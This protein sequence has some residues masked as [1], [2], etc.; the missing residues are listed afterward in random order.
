ME[1]VGEVIDVTEEEKEDALI[2]QLLEKKVT[3]ITEAMDR[4]ITPYVAVI[5][6]L[7]SCSESWAPVIQPIMDRLKK[8]LRN[9]H[10]ENIRYIPSK[11]DLMTP[12]FFTN[13]HKIRV[14]VLGQDPYHQPENPMGLAFSV[15]K[16]V[17]IP[18]SLKNIFTAAIECKAMS[19]YPNHGS[20]IQWALQGV[21]LLNVALTVEPNSPG[22]HL[23]QW[24][25]FTIPLIKSIAASSKN[26]IFVL[27][28]SPA[29][30]MR[31]YCELDNYRGNNH[32]F[33]EGPHP[34]ARGNEYLTCTHLKQINDIFLERKEPPIKWDL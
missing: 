19:Q 13:F 29:Q 14:V 24:K 4:Q 5:L 31:K 6:T 23:T 21:F 28:G 1:E 27:W 34:V 3:I 20:L 12:F 33:L 17:P 8:L 7:E 15:R 32:L 26:L 25:Q 16:G 2:S 18:A 9:M 30:Q 10:K 22:S 11:W